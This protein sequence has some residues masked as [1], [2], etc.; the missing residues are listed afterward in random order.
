MTKSEMYTQ[1]TELLNRCKEIMGAKNADYSNDV[2]PFINFNQ[3][4]LLTK[5]KISRDQGVLVRMTDKL[6][7]VHRLLENEAQVKDE[8]IEDTLI[9][10]ANYSL[11]LIL[12][13]RDRK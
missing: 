5:G 9:D 11:L 1:F 12:L 8:T 4:E 10:L 13:R 3:I 6:S 2:D 7:R